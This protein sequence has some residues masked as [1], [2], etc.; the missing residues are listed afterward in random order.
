MRA[1]DQSMHHIFI[2]R[3]ANI[4]S[5]Q[6]GYMPVLKRLLDWQNTMKNTPPKHTEFWHHLNLP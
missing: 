2:R 5:S 4:A 3:V 1:F 6:S